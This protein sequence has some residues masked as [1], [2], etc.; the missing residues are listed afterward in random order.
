MM[1]L[2]TL[3]H[4]PGVP[5]LWFVAERTRARQPGHCPSPKAP[6]P[7]SPLGSLPPARPAPLPGASWLA[8]ARARP[9][10]PGNAPVRLPVGRVPTRA[11]SAWYP[12]GPGSTGPGY[13]RQAGASGERLSPP[14]PL[15]RWLPPPTNFQEHR[16]SVAAGGSGRGGWCFTNGNAG[17][18]REKQHEG[19]A[20]LAVRLDDCGHPGIPG[21]ADVASAPAG[22]APSARALRAAAVRGWLSRTPEGWCSIG[23]PA[24]RTESEADHRDR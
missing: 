10:G 24:A 15:H 12:Q 1:A 3:G 19:R 6:P 2:T 17:F 22:A 5:S 18:A 4:G 11:P 9:Q 13:L 16:Q 8:L 23:A 7:P 14:P 20:S 21:T